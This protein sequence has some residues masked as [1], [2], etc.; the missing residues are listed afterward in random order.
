MV[1]K[2]I[3]YQYILLNI[4]NPKLPSS[5]PSRYFILDSHGYI[6]AY[7]R[8]PKKKLTT[9]LL[10]KLCRMVCYTDRKILFDNI[11]ET[12]FKI[13]EKEIRILKL[14]NFIIGENTKLIYYGEI[15]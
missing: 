3:I 11:A 1:P 10:E 9:R 12:C 8:I 13:D 2:Y 6:G 5:L 4:N 15:Y 7:S 14:K